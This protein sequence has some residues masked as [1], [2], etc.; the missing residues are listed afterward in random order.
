MN[1]GLVILF[2][3]SFVHTRSLNTWMWVGVDDVDDD[4]DD[5]ICKIHLRF[6]T[7]C[8]NTEGGA[9]TLYYVSY[10]IEPSV[11]QQAQFQ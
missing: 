3:Y 8:G 4:D 9:C 1:K 5:G 2:R 11:L 10:A 6:H 7:R